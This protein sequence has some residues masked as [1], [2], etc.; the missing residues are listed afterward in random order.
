MKHAPHRVGA[1]G[2]ALGAPCV[3]GQ[4]AAPAPPTA[5]GARATAGSPDPLAA[6][7]IDGIT[8]SSWKR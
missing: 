6:G 5:A 1:G 8:P 3:L 2:L 7:V 4:A